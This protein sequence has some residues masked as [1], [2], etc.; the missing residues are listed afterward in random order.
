MRTRPERNRLI[1]AGHFR[2][3]SPSSGTWREFVGRDSGLVS[4]PSLSIYLIRAVYR[5]LATQINSII[6][7]PSCRE[8]CLKVP[9][10]SV[11][12]TPAHP[13]LLRWTLAAY[14]R[15]AIR[16]RPDRAQVARTL[17]ARRLLQGRREFRQ[18]EILRAG[19][20]AVPQ[21]NAPHT[22]YPELCDRRR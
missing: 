8:I 15:K 20:A 22:P 5:F 19:D 18:A 7:S 10:E 9:N 12:R 21:R 13:L 17:G 11:A 3:P 6:G 4:R 16:P 2:C 1:F 14:V